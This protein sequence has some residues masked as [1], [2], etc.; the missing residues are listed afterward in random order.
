MTGNPAAPQDP[1]V[2]EVSIENALPAAKKAPA[3]KV[4]ATKP[5]Q[6]IPAAKVPT[7]RSY[8]ETFGTK[9]VPTVTKPS[10]QRSIRQILAACILPAFGHR[11]V[12]EMRQEYVDEFVGEQKARGSLRRRSTTGSRCCRVSCDT[13]TRME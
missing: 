2:K 6:E 12:D 13:P 5:A 7:I 9:Y 4:V 3:A 1:P 10:A 8:S 11:R